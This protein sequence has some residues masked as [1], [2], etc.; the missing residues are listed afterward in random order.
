M[1][2]CGLDDQPP[3]TP[4]DLVPP[5]RRMFVYRHCRFLVDTSGGRFRRV[6]FVPP[7]TGRA[8][9]AALASGISEAE[10]VR[11]AALPVP[12]LIAFA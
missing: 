10:A 12:P 7:S 11:W 5:R 3:D 1:V 9:N 6:R 8:L 4:I 2:H